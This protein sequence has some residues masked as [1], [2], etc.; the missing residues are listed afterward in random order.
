MVL[1]NDGNQRKIAIHTFNKVC[2]EQK[3]TKIV[4]SLIILDKVRKYTRLK[5]FLKS[6]EISFAVIEKL[7][8]I[9]ASFIFKN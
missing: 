5:F 9:L 3:R 4:P 2:G 1:E 7:S 6:K 8:K